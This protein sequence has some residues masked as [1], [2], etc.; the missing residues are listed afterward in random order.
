MDNDDRNKT[1]DSE[2]D[3]RNEMRYEKNFFQNER[4]MPKV[5]VKSSLLRKLIFYSD[6]AN[7]ATLL[8]Q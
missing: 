4:F 5:G 3:M 6:L 1:E 2:S 8:Q 7:R